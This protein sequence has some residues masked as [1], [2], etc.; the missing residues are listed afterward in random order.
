MVALCRVEFTSRA[1]DFG[2]PEPTV[3]GDGPVNRLLA[4]VGLDQVAVAEDLPDV[5]LVG[6]RAEKATRH[7]VVGWDVKVR[8]EEEGVVAPRRQVADS[9]LGAVDAFAPIVWNALEAVKKRPL[10]GRVADAA[11]RREGIAGKLDVPAAPFVEGVVA[12]V[13]AVFVEELDA[14]AEVAV[15]AFGPGNGAE[16]ADEYLRL[17][18]F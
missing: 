9:R 11:E 1:L 10:A 16:F 12:P 5:G 18:S 14:V 17:V 15:R 6:E 4:A 3:V 8:D 2:D 7:A 13:P